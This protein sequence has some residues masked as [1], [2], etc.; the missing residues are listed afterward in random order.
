VNLEKIEQEILQ[1]AIFQEKNIQKEIK[2]HFAIEC[3]RNARNRMIFRYWRGTQRC[4]REVLARELC[5]ESR[6]PL[7]QTELVRPRA[8]P[9]SPQRYQLLHE[10]Q[11]V[12]GGR[13]YE[14]RQATFTISLAC[15]EG[16]HA[17]LLAKVQ[18]W[19]VFLDGRFEAGGVVDGMPRFETLEQVRGWAEAE[20]TNQ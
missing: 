14:A 18:G 1:K 3:G 9:D 4:H 8:R 20:E 19:D 5:Q 17:P 2:E 11:V 16:A 7:K 15:P 13:T 10:E 12:V 6:C